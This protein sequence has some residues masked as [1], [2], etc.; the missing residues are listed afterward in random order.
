MGPAGTDLLI[1]RQRG[2]SSAMPGL[3]SF[4]LAALVGI[5]AVPAVL[6][7]ANAGYRTWAVALV[8]G[9]LPLVAA[10][11]RRPKEL[12]LFGWIVSLTYNR[13]YYSF[14][15][16]VGYNG[17]EGPYW[18][19]SD[20]LMLGLFGWALYE[21]LVN[22]RVSG[23]FG[24]RVWPWYLPFVIACLI[25]GI[26]AARPDWTAYEMLRVVKMG[27]VLFYVRYNVGKR[28]WWL[29]IASLAFAVSFQSVIGIKEVVTGHGGLLG[30]GAAP[31]GI[32]E[33][34]LPENFYGGIRITGTMVHPPYLASYM[35]L[36][37]PVL[38]A[39][40]LTAR[41][42]RAALS[43]IA[44]LT[45][46]V[47]LVF[48]LSRWPWAVAAAQFGLIL[49]AL[50]W[51]RELPAK[52]AVGILCIGLF[53]ALGIIGSFEQQF[54]GRMTRDWDESVALRR[55]G[56]NASFRMIRDYPLFGVGLN[57][58]MAYWLKYFPQMDY[59]LETEQYGSRILNLRAPVVMGNGLSHV[60][61]E[62]GIVGGLAFLVYL[63]GAFRFALR[64]VSRTSGECRAASL[65]L[66]VGILGILTEQLI[67]A[68]LWVD[69]NLYT[70]TLIIALLNN[71]GFLFAEARRET[72]TGMLAVESAA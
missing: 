44:F 24:A 8:M 40:S 51:L 37:L 31:E 21:R 60:V 63:A 72:Q 5:G 59:V 19:V 42:R 46:T 35:L 39:L 70:F 1:G 22:G 17:L 41:R 20:L 2:G 18:M 10:V 3:A 36:V 25:S 13:Q 28:E 58:S 56:L 64:A 6:Q 14:E 53:V 33:A 7:L 67:D 12:L 47:G 11:T 54:M 9:L 27:L 29:C 4:L 45:G 26:G 69:P 61:E 52:R 48:T 62:T 43:A 38:L 68:P 16:M 71:A 32:P 57:N 49:L 15:S 66:L 55:E 23:P 50:A 30:L 65:G 34:F